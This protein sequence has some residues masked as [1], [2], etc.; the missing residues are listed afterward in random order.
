MRYRQLGKT[1][2]MVSEIGLGC[3]HLENTTIEN[4]EAV[5]HTAL[6]AGVNLL[7][8]FMANPEIRTNIGNALYGRRKDVLLQG[9]I[10]A[11]WKNGQYARTRDPQECERFVNDFLERYRTDRIDLGMMHF[12]DTPK[13]FEMCFQTPYLD[14]CQKLKKDGRVRVLGASSHDARTALK[15]AESGEVDLILFS[16]NPAFDLLPPDTLLDQLFANK[17]YDTDRLG[18]NPERALLY[19]RCEELGV[20]ITVMK[21]YAAGRLFSPHASG[22]GVPLT[23]WQCIAYALDRPAVASVLIGASNPK[24]MEIALSYENASKDEK[25]YSLLASGT[26]S[27]I[28]GQCMYCN[29]C[30]PCPAQI[31]IAA[32]TKYLHMAGET[33]SPTV[34][35]H[36]A[37]LAAHAS[38]CTRCAACE[39]RCPFGVGVRGN[40]EEA[41]RVFGH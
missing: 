2:L 35:E 33:P 16:V 36:Y 21:T 29:H 6:D 26:R 11:T 32:V 30:L 28:R 1:P 10:G 7:D 15:I 14:L 24:E 31:D 27:A 34:A 8:V 38:D 22:F 19:R 5:V 39:A 40:M 41:I 18:V 25:D 3:E 13:D 9:H 17:T 23:P 20:A 12:I 4:I 37:A